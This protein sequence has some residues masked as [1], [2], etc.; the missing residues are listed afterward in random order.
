MNAIVSGKHARRTSFKAKTI[1]PLGI[2]KRDELAWL[3]NRYL[4]FGFFFSAATPYTSYHVTSVY[5]C[6]VVSI[7]Y[8]R[9]FSWKTW[10][11]LILASRNNAYLRLAFS[12]CL[13]SLCTSLFSFNSIFIFLDWSRSCLIQR[14]ATLIVHGF[15]SGFSSLNLHCSCKTYYKYHNLWYPCT[16]Y[17]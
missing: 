15:C 3:C 2:N 11:T 4:F 9:D 1:E 12:R 8:I 14:R 17:R 5:Y 16:K 6:T 13:V 10:W 7:L